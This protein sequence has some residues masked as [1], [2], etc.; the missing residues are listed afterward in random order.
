MIDFIG[1]GLTRKMVLLLLV[2]SLVPMF[3]LSMIG[4]QMSEQMRSDFLGKLEQQ[5]DEKVLLVD[6]SIK[7]R[8][9][10]MEVLSHHILF[11][12]LIS[13]LPNVQV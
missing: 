12:E 6:A 4:Y 5:F 9:F 11:Q 10:E 2:L 3:I 13:D 8:I 1:K 7:Q